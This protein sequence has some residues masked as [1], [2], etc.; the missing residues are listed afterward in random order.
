M[1]HWFTST[2]LTSIKGLPSTER[3]INKLAEREGWESQKRAFGKG[4]E[5]HIS[6]L[7]ID[8][9]KALETQA[10]EQLLPTVT[11]S[12]VVVTANDTGLTHRQREA[13]D[14]R[15]TIVRTIESMNAQGITK[16]AAMTTLLSQAAMGALEGSSP[17]LDKALRM[18]KDPRGRGDSAYPSARTLKR[19]LSPNTKTLAPKGKRELVIPDWAITFMACYQL[20]EKPTVEHA[21]RTFAKQWPNNTPSI[22]SV[23]RLLKKVGNVS[24]ERGRM[25][26]REIK[27]LM[28]FIRRT[29]ED[30]VPADIYTADGHTFDAEVSH[31]RH[32][33]PFRPEITT[34]ID[35]ATRRAVGYSVDLAESGIAVLDALIDSCTQAVPA[36]LYVDNG[37]GYCNALLKDESLGVLAR[38]GTDIRHSL[39]YNSQARGVIER[40]HQTLWIDGAKSIAGYIGKDMDRQAAQLQ[41]KLSRKALKESG[42]THLLGWD[43]FIEFCEDRMDFYNNKPHSSLPKITDS[44][45][46]R[47]TM[48]PNESWISHESNGWIAHLL[49]QDQA[50]DVFRPRMTR[51]VL[52]GEIRLLNNRYFSRDLEEFH[53]DSVQIAFDFRDAQFIWVYDQDGRLICKAEWNANNAHYMP[54]SYVMQAREKRADARI[55][56][57]EVKIDEIEAERRGYGSIDQ[58]TPTFIPGIGN[59][60]DIQ[61]RLK[62]KQPAD[63]IEVEVNGPRMPEQMTPDERLQTYQAYERGTDVPEEHQRWVTTYPRSKEYKSLT[64]RYAEF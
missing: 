20:P 49:T 47:R 1:K 9:R 15:T 63:I 3:G 6:N 35:I 57:V 10:I 58:N 51:K 42:K 26:P 36:M 48:T 14:A 8:A 32:G 40:V 22:H 39:P 2:E 61:T 41:H 28:P 45:G 38:L 24:R 46:K 54:M 64:Q 31:P 62:A 16:E 53:G 55:K 44:A 56:R 43:N 30:L 27:N 60:H 50:T 34:F 33:R 7:S 5:Y 52:R 17:V 12:N 25:G 18:A 11:T 29:F 19:W 21:Y 13:T 37:S 4:Y 23:R 59:V